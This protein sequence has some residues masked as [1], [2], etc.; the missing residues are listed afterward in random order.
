[1][2]HFLKRPQ[3]SPLHKVLLAMFGTLFLSCA[4]LIGWQHYE[5]RQELYRETADQLSNITALLAAQT[6]G[7]N[8]AML[9]QKYREPG[10]I[11]RNTQDAWYYV[12]QRSLA[13][14]A[15]AN[16]LTAPVR[17]LAYDTARKQVQVIVTSD[18]M[19]E[20]RAP[21]QE[22]TG[23]VEAMLI[24]GRA[25]RTGGE[26]EHL[27]SAAPLIDRH[28]EIS[29]IVLAQRPKAEIEEA[30]RAGLWRNL[31]IM[32]AVFALAALVLFRS[33]VKW[34]KQAEADRVEL[35]RK[36]A[37]ITDSIA[38]AGK[39]QNALIPSP[40][41]FGELFE[42]F[43]VLNRP[44]DT[45]SGDFHWYHRA[46]ENV[47]W[48]ATAD[49]TGHGLPGAMMAAIG[50]SILNDVVQ[51]NPD[52]DPASILSQL[53]ERL[54]RTMHQSGQRKGA[55][56]GMDIALCRI[57]RDQREVLFAGAYRP[58]Y[59]VH[60]GELNIINGDRKPIGGNH[61]DAERKFSTHRIVYA[62]GDRIYLFSDG[63]ADQF[64]GP[65]RKKFM[66]ARFNRMLLEH[67]GLD[68]RAQ[69]ERFDETF[70]DWKG[71]EE[72][73]DDVCVLGLQV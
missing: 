2:S 7:D 63:Y 42:H 12:A 4:G 69:K 19:P 25:H 30:A 52:A 64:G 45:V 26:S 22:P 41:V 72:Q 59:W 37:G 10:L 11:I 60:G 28:G 49:C 14:V 16:R 3:L 8:I 40:E 46:G 53:S 50:C 31:T 65:E 73:V 71:P 27:S 55:G 29:G 13:R 18:P 39:I 61:H 21:F 9:V 51:Q 48:V 34:I 33:A 17:I 44:K 43:F 38:Y 32:L 68:M 70:T 23:L 6:D 24:P 1:M 57:D 54:T 67:Q 58:M 62:A 20:Y 56:D 35:A 5:Q 66:I 15:E 47:C 36:H